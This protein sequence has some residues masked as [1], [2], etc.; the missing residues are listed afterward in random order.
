MRR[1]GRL[2]QVDG[3]G[4]QPKTAIFRSG[5][6]GG[7]SPGSQNLRAWRHPGRLA[8]RHRPVRRGAM[9]AGSISA[10]LMRETARRGHN[11]G[12]LPWHRYRFLSSEKIRLSPKGGDRQFF[13]ER[14]PPRLHSSLLA[15][16]CSSAARPDSTVLFIDGPRPALLP[17]TPHRMDGGQLNRSSGN[18]DI[19]AFRNDLHRVGRQPFIVGGRFEKVTAASFLIRSDWRP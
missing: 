16:C 14:T 11:L 8:W 10:D 5:A 6:K 18:I 19:F 12:V 2:A 15:G 17:G 1:Q 4:R 9:Q 3:F 7:I 13:T